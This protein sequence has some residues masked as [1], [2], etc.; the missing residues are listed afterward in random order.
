MK[1]I[2]T[3]IDRLCNHLQRDRNRNTT[4]LIAF[5]DRDHN[6]NIEISIFIDSPKHKKLDIFENF[7]QKSNTFN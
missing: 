2:N 4:I 7:I 1:E 6:R 3:K 5:S